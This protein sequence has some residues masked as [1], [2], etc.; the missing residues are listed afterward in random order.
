MQECDQAQHNRTAIKMSPP[1]IK[2]D[3][4]TNFWV[5]RVFEFPHL[6]NL[7][8]KAHFPFSPWYLSKFQITWDSGNNHALPLNI[9]K[10][11]KPSTSFWL[12]HVH[13][14]FPLL[15]H[16]WLKLSPSWGIL[17]VFTMLARSLLLHVLVPGVIHKHS[18]IL[19]WGWEKNCLAAS[20][21]G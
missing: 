1:G 8:K 7:K 11:A 3:S 16:S 9:I 12:H 17:L 20:R 18:Q 10:T 13:T 15:F 19:K 6:Y 5:L 14:S 21:G 2:K 4:T